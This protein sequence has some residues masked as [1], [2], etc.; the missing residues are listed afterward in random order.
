M[1]TTNT[2]ATERLAYGICEFAKVAGIARQRA[3]NEARSGRLRTFKLGK[4]RMVT[5]QAAAEWLA[6]VEREG[7]AE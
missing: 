1:A 7:A 6:R 5:A 4:R 3:F 2:S